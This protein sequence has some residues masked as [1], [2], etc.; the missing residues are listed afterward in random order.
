[1]EVKIPIQVDAFAAPLA[2][3]LVSD[4]M[5]GR[6]ILSPKADLAKKEGFPFENQKIYI[7]IG[8]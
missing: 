7:W 3:P 6:T 1:M 8:G 4:T 2:A 5:G